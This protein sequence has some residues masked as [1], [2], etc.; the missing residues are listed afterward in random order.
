[1]SRRFIHLNR[2]AIMK[3]RMVAV[4]LVLCFAG[5]AL[6]LAA[7][8]NMGSGSWKLNEAKSK[9]SPGAPKSTMVVYEPAGDS[10][11]VT[12]DGTSF[13][14]KPTHTEWTG[15]FDGKDYPVTGDSNQSA[16]SYTQVNARTLKF[17]VKSDD[18]VV[19]SGSIMIA[20]DGMSRTVTASG[21][22]AGGKKISY[23][24][25]YDKQ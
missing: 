14:G 10:V 21:A 25:V 7:D 20:A 16:R 18:K 11:K 1:M 8:A 6:C 9:F 23:T 5:A 24:A 17:K 19:L 2:E 13:D 22:S 4:S 15:K 12:I 3:A